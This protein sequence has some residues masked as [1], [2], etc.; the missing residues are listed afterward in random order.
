MHLEQLLQRR[1]DLWR[2]RE[3]AATTPAGIASGFPELD[4][5]LP[6]GGWPPSGLVEILSAHAGDGSFAL[7]VPA[8]AALSR[9]GRWLL[10]I[11]PPYL[12]Y[13]PALAWQGVELGRLLVLPLAQPAEAAWAA[14]QGSRS[15]ACRAV[16]IWGG[17]WQATSLRRLQLA[18]E[19]GGAL[20]WLFRSPSAA[21]EASPAPLRLR[22]RGQRSGLGVQILKQRGGGPAP[23]FELWPWGLD[24]PPAP[25]P[26]SGRPG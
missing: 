25:Q 18:A 24:R 22:V 26:T 15:G 12:P 8:L 13:A 9:E 1:S 6:W 5:R 19:A 20:A 16:L 14:E 7:L 11:N 10:L 17:A 2:G 4:G 21:G 23:P 3:I